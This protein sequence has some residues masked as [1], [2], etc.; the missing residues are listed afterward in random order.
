MKSFDVV[1]KAF[2]EKVLEIEAECWATEPSLFFYTNNKQ[3]YK[4]EE[5]K[6]AKALER[7]EKRLNKNPLDNVSKEVI[8][9]CQ[10]SK[11]VPNFRDKVAKKKV[12]KGNRKNARPLHYDNLVEYVLAT[13]EVVFAEGCEAD[14]LLAVWQCKAEPLTTII[15][16]RDKDLKIVPG[17]HFG[18]QCGYQPQFGPAQVSLLGEISLNKRRTEI[19]GTGLKFFYSQVLTGDKTDDYP[20]L[21]RCGA[22]KAFDLL[23]Q[24]NDEAELFKAVIGAYKSFYGEETARD[25]MFEQACLA[26]MVQELDDE[27]GLIHY[28]MYDKR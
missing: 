3:L 4:R 8:E 1:S 15:C 6:K 14:D 13:R 24:C 22:V 16:S 5:K 19:K 25:E 27:G 20:G 10:P 12:Y 9:T 21:P 2:D 18:W 28:V 23:E 11:Y 26:W 7:A 17:M